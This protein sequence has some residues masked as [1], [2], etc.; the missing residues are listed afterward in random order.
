MSAARSYHVASVTAQPLLDRLETVRSNG[1]GWTARCPAHADR[2]PSLSISETAD[3]VLVHCF[4]GCHPGAVLD[5]VGLS[6]SDLFP[7]RHWPDGKEQRLQNQRSIRE[8]ARDASL[9]A[10]AL[11]SK[12]ALIAARQVASGK[13]LSEEDDE[14]LAAAVERIDLAANTLLE[15]RWRPMSQEEESRQRV[16][17]ARHVLRGLPQAEAL[18]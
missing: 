12:V 2:G 3:K 17:L 13:P 9:E 10:L 4:A 11:E 14:R 1:K 5:A 6:W 8:A 18:R 16:K 7:P 15:H